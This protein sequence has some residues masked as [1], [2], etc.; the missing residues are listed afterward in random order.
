MF[1]ISHNTLRSQ[2]SHYRINGICSDRVRDNPSDVPNPWSTLTSLA[3]H[4]NR[5]VKRASYY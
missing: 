5:G 4:E 3:T 2:S 1:L